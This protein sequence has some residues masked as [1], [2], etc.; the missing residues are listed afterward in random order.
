MDNST[1]ALIELNSK[2]I[3][4]IKDSIDDKKMIYEVENTF[5]DGV[6]VSSEITFDKQR[7]LDLLNSSLDI[8]RNSLV[9]NH[10]YITTFPN[11]RESHIR[12][13]FND[14]QYV[15]IYVAEHRMRICFHVLKMSKSAVFPDPMC[16]IPFI[17]LDEDKATVKSIT[18]NDKFKIDVDLG[19]KRYLMIPKKLK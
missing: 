14:R 6:L 16:K 15:H 10:L 13:L 8:C 18:Y 17:D 2:V 12:W 5:H 1:N 11:R 4:L 3:K 19:I 7:A 9:W